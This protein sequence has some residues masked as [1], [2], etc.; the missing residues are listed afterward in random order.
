M[1]DP[2]MAENRRRLCQTRTREEIDDGPYNPFEKFAEFFNDP[3]YAPLP[4]QIY[5]NGILACDVS[6]ISPAVLTH[7]R[8]GSCL[9]RQWNSKKSGYTIQLAKFRESGQNRPDTWTSFSHCTNVPSAIINYLH[10]FLNTS[11]GSVLMDTATRTLPDGMEREGCVSGNGPPVW[12]PGSDRARRRRA[13]RNEDRDT[14]QVQ[15]ISFV[16][17]ENFGRGKSSEAS[18]AEELKRSKYNSFGEISNLVERAEKAVE[19]LVEQD[20]TGKSAEYI[21]IHTAKKRRPMENLEA[22]RGAE[23][24]AQAAIMSSRAPG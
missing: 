9:Q 13:L 15:Q 19:D 18:D 23:D 17:G 12:T 8:D 2:A 16:G 4:V 14:S 10:S 21:A 7:E 24:D 11:Q 5:A 1:A 3:E 20:V 6:G 22:L